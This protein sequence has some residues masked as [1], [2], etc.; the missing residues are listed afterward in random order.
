MPTIKAL[1]LARHLQEEPLMPVYLLVGRDESLGARCLRQFK[2]AVEKPDLPG[3]TTVEFDDKTA[4]GRVFDELRTLPFMGMSGRRLVILRQGSSFI[5]QYGEQLEEYLK[6]PALTGTLVLWCIGADRSSRGGGGSGGP[7]KQVAR[8]TRQNVPT[9]DCKA[10]SWREAEGWI[11]SLAQTLGKKLTPRAGA[12]LVEAIGPDLSHLENE[13]RKLVEYAADRSPI[14]VRDVEE[15]VPQSR[16]RSI[17]QAADAVCGKNAAEALRLCRQVLLRGDTVQGIVSVLS[18][19]VRQLWQTKRILGSGSGT[20]EVAKELGLESFMAQKLSKLAP[21]LTDQWFVQ[22]L[23]ILS[24]A[25]LESKTT[26]MKP[27]EE[28]IWLDSL[29]VALCRQ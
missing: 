26:S 8:L 18:T 1:G 6:K 9:V 14:T 15:L 10:P 5:A 20:R 22:S 3:S 21:R 19:R 28:E 12:A 17:F 23:R 7:N 4:P 11:D 2:A 25:D 27:G 16:S 29:L 13:L 24:R